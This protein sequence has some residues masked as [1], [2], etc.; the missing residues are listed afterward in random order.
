MLARTNSA[1]YSNSTFDF[2]NFLVFKS[3]NSNDA[4]CH[5]NRNKALFKHGMLK[6]IIH[7][8]IYQEGFNNWSFKH[9]STLFLMGPLKQ[10]KNMFAKTRAIAT[11][12]MIL[13][14]FLTLCSAFWWK[15]NVLALMFVVIQFCA[16]TWYSISYIP[17]ARDAVCSCIDKLI[18][19]SATTATTNTIKIQYKT[20]HPALTVITSYLLF[21][22]CNRPCQI[23]IIN[24]YQ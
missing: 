6:V 24:I 15:K 5:W 4:W 12:V 19:W 9:S 13:A 17:Y 10:L 18:S 23:L 7:Y 8:Y 21:H 11:I 3:F 22:V 1:S 14:F 20:L 2:H 16:M